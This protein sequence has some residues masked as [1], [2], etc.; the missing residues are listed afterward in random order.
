MGS[1]V[2]PR[3]GQNDIRGDRLGEMG[4]RSWEGF[5]EGQKAV[6]R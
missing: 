4:R 1:Q 6:E 2:L 3:E 5:W